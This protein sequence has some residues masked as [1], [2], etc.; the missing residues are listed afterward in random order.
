MLIQLGRYDWGLTTVLIS[1]EKVRFNKENTAQCFVKSASVC[2]HLALGDTRIINDNVLR[3]ANGSS[4]IAVRSDMT[5]I[6]LYRL[7]RR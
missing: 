7:R 1:T 6:L 2:V 3:I 5:G 4:L